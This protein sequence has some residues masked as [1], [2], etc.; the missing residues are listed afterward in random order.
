MFWRPSL[1]H[2]QG[3]IITTCQPTG[4]YHNLYIT[5]QVTSLFTINLA[6]SCT[7]GYFYGLKFMTN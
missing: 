7:T 4:F 5:Q 2:H 6:A 1:L 3:T